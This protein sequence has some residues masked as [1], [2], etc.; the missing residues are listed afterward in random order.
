[1]IPPFYRIDLYSSHD[2]LASVTEIDLY[3]VNRRL[4]TTDLV[5]AKFGTP[6]AV[7]PRYIPEHLV[8][9]YPGMVVYLESNPLFEAKRIA[10]SARIAQINLLE[11]NIRDCSQMTFSESTLPWRG[12]RM[13]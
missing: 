10:P 2:D 3:F 1:M 8:L 11:N 13:Y 7:I 9:I 12:F 6:C 5:V 4:V